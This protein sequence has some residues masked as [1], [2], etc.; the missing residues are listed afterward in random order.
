[1]PTPKSQLLQAEQ[2]ALQLFDKIEELGLIVPGKSEK[3]LNDEI[4]KLAADFLGTRKF[5]H[6]RI[7]RAGKNTLCP[8]KENPPDHILQENDILFFDFG[9]VF[10][11]W[12]ADIGITSVLGDD[13]TRHQLKSDVEKAWEEG[14]AYFE[15]HRE[16]ITGAE[17]Y[18]FTCEMAKRY[19]WQ[20][21]NEHCGHLVGRFP[22]E[23]L[24]GEERI[25]YIHPDNHQRMSAP[26]QHGE[27]RHW[28]YEIH[29]VDTEKQ[30]GGFY[31][32][33]LS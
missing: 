9:P 12:E 2:K 5:W 20:Y 25:N 16:Y 31:E 30:I 14:K 8:Y 18:A 1:M 6:K 3:Q 26:D 10:E 17:L 22:H 19:G 11:Q 4:L 21:G 24:L 32:R 15:K 23:Q 28:I 33:L 13:P 27:E 7:V 29:F